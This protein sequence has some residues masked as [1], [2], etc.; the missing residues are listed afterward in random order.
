MLQIVGA[1]VLAAGRDRARELFDFLEGVNWTIAL[2]L[3]LG[4]LTVAAIL[5]LAVAEALFQ[6]SRLILDAN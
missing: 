5:L 4:V 2:L 3:V 1:V 6:R